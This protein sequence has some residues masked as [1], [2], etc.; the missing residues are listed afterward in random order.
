MTV[1][2]RAVVERT[3]T[4]DASSQ[5]SGTNASTPL[6]FPQSLSFYGDLA[7][8]AV[9]RIAVENSTEYL[10]PP[11]K[12]VVLVA[13][14]AQRSQTGNIEAGYRNPWFN[15][16]A[17]RESNFQH[18]LRPSSADSSCRVVSRLSQRG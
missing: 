9:L 1:G 13:V 18:Y 5:S 10:L 11:G 4:L 14:T 16:I 8:G 17:V 15:I 2:G 7:E 12:Q 6:I 3:T